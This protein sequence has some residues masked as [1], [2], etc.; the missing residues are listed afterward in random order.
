M[1]IYRVYVGQN[2]Y[3]I[4][5]TD[6]SVLVNGELVQADLVPLNEVGSYLLR[7]G[8]RKREIQVNAEGESLYSMT[9]RGRK[10][11]ARVEKGFNRM[12]NQANQECADIITAPM[13]GMVISILVKEGEAVKKDQIL[14]ILESM[15]MQMEMRAPFEGQIAQI[16]IQPDCQ[17]NKGSSLVRLLQ[18]K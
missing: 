11:I 8:N 15:K 17:V 18:S 6:K 12:K 2:E 16:Y 10:I 4:N 14:V 7:L 1:T 5:V 9:T 13:P 3:H